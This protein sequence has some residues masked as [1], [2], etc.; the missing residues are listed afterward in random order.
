MELNK[1]HL[2]EIKE[3]LNLKTFIIK[4]LSG[5]LPAIKSIK[6]YQFTAKISTLGTPER[7]CD[8]SLRAWRSK[9]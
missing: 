4:I 1:T 7:Q 5:L 2:Y 6:Q 8:F 9:V 3:I